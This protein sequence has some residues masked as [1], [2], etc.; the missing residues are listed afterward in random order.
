MKEVRITFVGDFVCPFC[1]FGLVQLT[2]GLELYEEALK[3]KGTSAGGKILV[4]HGAYQL[5]PDIPAAGKKKEK[6]KSGSGNSD[7]SRQAK[8]LGVQVKPARRIANTLNAHRLA[9]WS[10]TQNDDEGC[11]KAIPILQALYELRFEQGDF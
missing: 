6:N 3:K 9:L 5:N 10:Q 11:T 1:Y 4:E 2:K 8:K 7:I